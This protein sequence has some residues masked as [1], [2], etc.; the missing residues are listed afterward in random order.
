MVNRHAMCFQFYIQC[1]EVKHIK[2]M[3]SRCMHAFSNRF[4]F[5]IVFIWIDRVFGCNLKRICII[6]YSKQDYY[7][8]LVLYSVHEGGKMK[9]MFTKYTHAFHTK[10]L[11]IIVFTPLTIVLA[12]WKGSGLSSKYMVKM[13]AM[14]LHFYIQFMESLIKKMIT[15]YMQVISCL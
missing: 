13:N 10:I 8:V 1:L 11:L 6:R 15:K 14:I 2:T 7:A 12:I 5:T 9:T 4:M 3:F